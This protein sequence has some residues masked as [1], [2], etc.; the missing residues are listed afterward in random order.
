MKS[1]DRPDPLICHFARKPVFHS[2]RPGARARSRLR[3]SLSFGRRARAP[4]GPSLF[5][6]KVKLY[7]SHYTSDRVNNNRNHNNNKQQQQQQRSESSHSR[8]THIRR[9]TLFRDIDEFRIRPV[10]IIVKIAFRYVPRVHSCACY[11]HSRVLAPRW[12]RT[13]VSNLRLA[14]FTD[15]SSGPGK[16]VHVKRFRCFV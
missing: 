4:A 14:K 8:T 12:T 1:S 2:I 5:S 9:V 3:D 7:A 16:D 10:V 13:G 15:L 6:P 11:T